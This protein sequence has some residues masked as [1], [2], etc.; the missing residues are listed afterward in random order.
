M[1]ISQ[2][3]KM[4]KIWYTH[5]TFLHS[6]YYSDDEIAKRWS[7]LAYS[8]DIT[9]CYS[10]SH[11]RSGRGDGNLRSGNRYYYRSGYGV[12]ATRAR[13]YSTNDNSTTTMKGFIN[14]FLSKL[15]QETFETKKQSNVYEYQ[16]K[17]FSI[18][19]MWSNDYQ[20]GKLFKEPFW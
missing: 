20:T 15:E 18:L 11:S 6:I 1:P 7:K 13:W 9:Y 10:V 17:V 3:R 14:Q 16:F 4:M 12:L 19:N 8:G 2:K 5:R